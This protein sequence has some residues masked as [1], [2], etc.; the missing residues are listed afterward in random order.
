MENLIKE[1]ASTRLFK[2]NF[3]PSPCPNVP[4]TCSDDVQVTVIL[5][6]IPIIY[7]LPHDKTPKWYDIVHLAKTQMSLGICQV[8][9]ESLPLA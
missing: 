2:L 5:I 6:Y 9:S 8:K 1:C 4:G 3:S 7:E